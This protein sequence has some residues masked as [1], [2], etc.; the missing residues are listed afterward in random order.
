MVRKSYDEK[1]YRRYLMELLG[2]K[3]YSS[4]SEVTEVGQRVR[5]ED[6]GST[7]S[8][9]LGM[10]EAIE[11]VRAAESHRLALGCMSYY[12]VVH[13]TVIGVETSQQL[14]LAGRQ[15]DVL[16]GCVG[17]G[18]NLMGFAGPYIASLGDSGA[19]RV[20]AVEPASVPCLTSGEF[21]YDWADYNRTT[22]RIAMYSLGNEF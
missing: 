15:P 21:R 20:V 10:S 19:P 8:L 9:G 2:A 3:V 14:A 22:P 7:G 4:P 12:A 1:P 11:L 18:S 16:I 17:G 13:Q 5:R 6:P